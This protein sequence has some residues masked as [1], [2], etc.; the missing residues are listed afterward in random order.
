MAT[1][2]ISHL[3]FEYEG[4]SP[5][6]DN[7]SLRLDTRWKLGLIGRNGRGKTTLLRLLLGQ[8]PFDGTIEIPVSLDYFPYAVSDEYQSALEIAEEIESVSLLL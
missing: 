4:G 1:I 5:L 8:L 2:S 6:F 3:T 7:V